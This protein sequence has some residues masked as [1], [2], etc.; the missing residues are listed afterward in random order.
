M[1]AAL[2]ESDLEV[3]DELNPTGNPGENEEFVDLNANP[4][5]QQQ[6]QQPQQQQQEPQAQPNNDDEL[7]EDLRGKSPKEIARMLREAQSLIGR[8][9]SELGELRRTADIAIRVA[10]AARGQP[11]AQPNQQGNQGAQQQGAQQGATQEID[12]S[13]F[14]AKPKE[15]IDTLIANHPRIKQIETML[16]ESAKNAEIA[17]AT[18]NTERFNAAHPDAGQIMQDPEFRKWV[19]SSRV[20]SALLQRAHTQFDFEAGDEVFGTWKALK[21]KTGQQQQQQ[22]QQQGGQGDVS[23]AARTLA[24]Q[25]RKAADQAAQTPTGGNASGTR[26][27]TVKIYRRAAVL[28]LMEENPDR[29]LELAPEIEQAYK[30]GRVR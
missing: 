2:P 28:K 1:A 7:P 11:A 27:Q 23:A 22:G 8:Q 4:S 19:G 30:E 24:A 10:A 3:V 17:R 18:A 29:Y 6:E 16:G 25:R 12:E 21:G 20:R 15:T 26:Q 13:Q 9:G 5:A 14:F